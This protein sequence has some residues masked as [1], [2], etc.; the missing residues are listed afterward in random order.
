MTSDVPD[1]MN[2]TTE[3]IL[4]TDGTKPL[5]YLRRNQVLSLLGHHPNPADLVDSLPPAMELIQGDSIMPIYLWCDVYALLV[6]VG[7]D[8]QNKPLN[9]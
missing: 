1:V 4:G 8:K 9:N 5:T 2:Y 6:K 7:L 3:Y